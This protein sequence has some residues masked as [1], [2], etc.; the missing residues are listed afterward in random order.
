MSTIAVFLKTTLEADDNAK[1]NECH[2]V[3]RCGNLLPLELGTSPSLKKFIAIKA[4]DWL[5][6]QTV[7]ETRLPDETNNEYEGRMNEAVNSALSDLQEG[8]YEASIMSVGLFIT[9][10]GNK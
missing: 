4:V 6:S 10:R 1:M 5:D 7:D 3:S 8:H 2:K 9:A